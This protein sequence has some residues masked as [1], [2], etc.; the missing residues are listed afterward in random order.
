MRKL[1]R[2]T[3]M[4]LTISSSLLMATLSVSANGLNAAESVIQDSLGNKPAAQSPNT[5]QA[6]KSSG[7]FFSNWFLQ[8]FKSNA[9]A[10]SDKLLSNV[11]IFP[12]P[13]VESINLSY[14]LGKRSDVSIKVMDALGNELLTL[15]SQN[16]DSGNQNHSF[17]IQKRLSPGLYFLKVTA[18]TET[19]IKR[20]SIL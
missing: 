3:C 8:P 15:F 11:K 6:T 18:G 9:Q 5:K 20:I 16:V 1:L 7:S 17:D 4:V 2:D 10:P 19:V 12:N 13:T 14:R